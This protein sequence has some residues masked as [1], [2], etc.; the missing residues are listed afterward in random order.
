MSDRT[1][2]PDMQLFKK[3]VIERFLIAARTIY[4]NHPTY[5]YDEYSAL[6]TKIHI[7]PTY[8]NQNFEGKNPRLLAKVG[9]Y[10][11]SL[12]DFLGGNLAEDVMNADGVI[13]G[14]SSMKNMTTMIT[15]IVRAYAEEESAD[16][17]DELAHLGVFSAHHMFTQVGLNIRG[18]AVSE[19]RETNN[20][21]DTFDTMVNLTVDVPWEM[22][23]FSGKAAAEPE[24]E[25]DIP[26][27]VIEGYRP[28]G[29]YVINGKFVK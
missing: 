12:Q 6:D 20:Q 15:I 24:P 2:F 29:T 18:S 14:Y 16:L 17:A 8:A 9:Q 4:A 26:A 11:F 25:I 21:D 13:G 5:R 3:T 7:E 27:D 1:I 22:K 28:P 10:E 23:K 19:T